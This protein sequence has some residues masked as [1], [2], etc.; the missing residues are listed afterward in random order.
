M[1]LLSC[2]HTLVNLDTLTRPEFRTHLFADRIDFASDSIAAGL[3]RIRF[4]GQ[5]VQL[6]A[7]AHMA[8]LS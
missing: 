4:V 3:A 1:G 7:D 8:T 5:C 2:T 6:A